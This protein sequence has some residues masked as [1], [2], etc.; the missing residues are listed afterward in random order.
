MPEKS[1]TVS[2][3]TLASLERGLDALTTEVADRRPWWRRGL[4]TVVPPLCAVAFLLAVWQALVMAKVKPDYLLPSPAQV[5]ASVSEQWNL[6][7]LPRAIWLSVSRGLFGFAVS[8]AVATP[9]GLLV[10]RVRV[11]RAAIGSLLSGLQTLPSV[12]WVP[13]AILWFGL[14]PMTIFVV[15]LLGAVPSIANGMVAGIDQIQ[16]LHLRVGRV[17]GARGLTAARHIVLPAALP[18][19][20]A[21]LKQGWAFSWRSLMAAELIAQSP[22]LGTGL[23]QLMDTGRELTDMSLVFG[24]IV[25]ILLVGVAIDQLI[26]TPL[27]RVTLRRRGLA[28]A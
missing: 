24:M 28:Q 1:S 14:S 4:G 6:G 7:A 11:V 23:G 10:A 18:G 12:A 22:R 20:L 3:D 5:W 16:P 26:F 9:L 21:G 19:Y 17:L 27:E 13:A 2:E 25:V 8:V 15:V